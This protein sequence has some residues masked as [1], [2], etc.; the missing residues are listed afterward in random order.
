LPSKTKPKITTGPVVLY[1]A[2]LV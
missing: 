2:H 1:S